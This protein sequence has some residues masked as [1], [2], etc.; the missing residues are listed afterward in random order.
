MTTETEK[1]AE[2]LRAQAAVHFRFAAKGE[3]DATGN[4]LL[5]AA[6]EIERLSAECERLRGAFR[7]LCEMDGDQPARGVWD[8]VRIS[9]KALGEGGE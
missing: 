2:F 6:D 7:L 1:L 3:R 4:G 9:R 5:H 8:M